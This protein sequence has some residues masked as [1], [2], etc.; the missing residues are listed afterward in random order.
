MDCRPPRRME[1]AHVCSLHSTGD[2]SVL[3]QSDR[4]RAHVAKWEVLYGLLGSSTD[5]VDSICNEIQPCCILCRD[6]CRVSAR[7][8]SAQARRRATQPSKMFDIFL[9][10]DDIRKA[11]YQKGE[12]PL[13]PQPKNW[14]KAGKG[15]VPKK[16][17]ESE[18][19]LVHPVHV[20]HH[21]FACS[22]SPCLMHQLAHVRVAMG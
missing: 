18:L 16:Q 17:R 11:I 22:L 10:P 3:E 12:P 15:D 9:E 20:S 14:L 8:E 4:I 2:P 19:R 13:D 6:P 21:V 5:V 1:Q 7:R